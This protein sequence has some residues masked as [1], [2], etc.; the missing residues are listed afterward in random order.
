MLIVYVFGVLLVE[1]GGRGSLMIWMVL[2]LGG[3]GV[4]MLVGLISGVVSI[5]RVFG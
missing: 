4:W 5:K 1:M 3:G 2:G